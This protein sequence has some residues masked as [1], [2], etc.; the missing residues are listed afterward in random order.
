MLSAKHLRQRFKPGEGGGTYAGGAGPGAA[1]GQQCAPAGISYKIK[2]SKHNVDVTH[3]HSQLAAQ[4]G[5]LLRDVRQL[6]LEV[7]NFAAKDKVL[8]ILKARGFETSW[9]ASERERNAGV[10]S[11][12]RRLARR[13][14]ARSGAARR[15]ARRG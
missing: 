8:D 1:A 2:R 12:V 7:E 6:A 9:F 11:E 10:K 13:G 5:V 15:S 14:A 3:S 4:L